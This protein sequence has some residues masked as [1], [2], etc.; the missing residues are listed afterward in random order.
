[1]TIAQK[2]RYAGDPTPFPSFIATVP[3]TAATDLACITVTIETTVEQNN[4]DTE[5]VEGAIEEAVSVSFNVP[6]NAVF[7]NYTDDSCQ[8]TVDQNDFNQLGKSNDSRR[9]LS[10]NSLEIPSYMNS[11]LSRISPFHALANDVSKQM[12]FSILIQIPGKY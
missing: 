10:M 1:V 2:T 3:P 5:D 8:T 4:W 6:M 11:A 7:V 12:K 9:T